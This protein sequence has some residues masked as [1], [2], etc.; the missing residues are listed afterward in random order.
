MIDVKVISTGSKGNAVFLDGQILIDCGVPFSKLA[1]AEVV[2]QIKYIFLTHQHKD[3]LN[4]TTLKRLLFENPLI[5]VIYNRYLV[6]PIADSFHCSSPFL[7]INR[8]FL[9]EINKWYAIGDIRFGAVPLHHD[10]PNCAWKIHFMR[11][12]GIFKVIYAT[13][14]ANLDGVAAKGYD[15]FLVEANYDKEEFA[16]VEQAVD[17]MFDVAIKLGGTGYVFWGGREG[18]YTLLNTQ[19]QREKDHLAKMLTAARDYARANGFKGT[20]L[21]EP[22]PMEPTKHQYDVDTETVIGFLRANGL[23]KDFKVN[24]EV[25]HATL[26]G[27]TF[28]HELTVARENGFLGSIDAN[29]GDAQNGWDTDQFPVD[30]FDLTQAMMQILLNGGFGNGG[31]NFDAKLRRSSTDPEDIFIA[32]ISAMDAMA[33][34]LLNAAAILEESPLPKMLKER[35]ASFDGGLGKK[36][37]EGK[38]SLEELY[39]YAKSNGEP[40]AAS[41]KQELCE[42][43]LNLYAK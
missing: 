10:V 42:T 1:D 18:Y 41:G 6:K 21:I 33:H 34:A 9:T 11:P 17:E 2:R 28:E 37:E 4:V 25:N 29:R 19:M 22:K 40:V 3:H 24:I 30:A 12:Q 15:L 5:R 36:F 20:F 31:T 38:A 32:H 8:S 14:T 16:R 43:Y 27:H 23:D 13:D 35:Y 39:E 7:F 26:A